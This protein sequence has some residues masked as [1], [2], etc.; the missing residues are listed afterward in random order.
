MLRNAPPLRQDHSCSSQSSEFNGEVSMSSSVLSR[1]TCDALEELQS[2]REMKNFLLSRSGVG[3]TLQESV[4]QNKS[5][6]RWIYRTRMASKIYGANCAS[7]NLYKNANASE[8]WW[9]PKDPVVYIWK[10]K[11][12]RLSWSEGLHTVDFTKIFSWF[13]TDYFACFSSTP[14]GECAWLT[15]SSV[16]TSSHS[17]LYV[18]ICSHLIIILWDCANASWW[19]LW[20]LL[21]FCP[22]CL[23]IHYYFFFWQCLQECALIREGFT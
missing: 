1:K 4:K 3:T 2:Y 14:A 11:T 15:F 18:S 19:L 8:Y 20:A 22:F 21:I 12:C 5:S 16:H 23:D 17:Q 6:K 13:K 10:S 9:F 7:A